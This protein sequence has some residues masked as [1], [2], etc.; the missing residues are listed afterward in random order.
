MQAWRGVAWSGVA[1]SGVEW[2]SW[3]G[4]SEAWRGVALLELDAGAH[5][6][7]NGLK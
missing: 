3:A 4:S 5:L 7:L 6:A 2:R 1:W